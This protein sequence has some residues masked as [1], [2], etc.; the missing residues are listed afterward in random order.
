MNGRVQNRLR[1]WTENWRKPLKY[2]ENT[3]KYY[4]RAVKRG[5]SGSSA[6][7]FPRYRFTTSHTNQLWARMQPRQK[8]EWYLMQ[9][10]NA[11]NRA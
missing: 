8:Y 7:E 4:E 10:P 6:R 9:Q 1:M 11:S 5:N 2:S 3:K